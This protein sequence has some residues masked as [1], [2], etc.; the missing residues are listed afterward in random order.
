MTVQLIAAVIIL[1]GIGYAVMR[2]FN[3][4][5]TKEREKTE[6]NVLKI[7]TA[8]EDIDARPPAD[9]ADLLKRMSDDANK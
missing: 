6:S 5:E 9:P 7:K 2:I 3:A 4:G 8:Q 1:L